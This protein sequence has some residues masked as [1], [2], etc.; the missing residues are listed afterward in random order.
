MWK[1]LHIFKIITGYIL[2]TALLVGTVLAF[3][4]AIPPGPVGVT[5]MKL[6]L[7]KGIRPS[8]QFAI[9]TGL[10]DAIFCMAAIFSTSA[11]VAGLSD[12]SANHPLATM[13]L[14][15]SII[16]GFLVFGVVNLKKKTKAECSSQESENVRQN[17]L[18]IKLKNK[19]PFF[20]GIAIAVANIANPTFLPS[21][22]YLTMQVHQFKFFANSLFN[23]FIF[24]IGFG[25]GNFLW[26]YLLVTVVM[27][28]QS[29]M[30][31]DFIEKIRQFAGITFIG[32]GGFLGWRLL[33]FTKW[34]EIFRLAFAF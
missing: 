27:K 9:G 3:V 15:L 1:K 23:N 21:L 16:F 17:A 34:T 2:P 11:V 24:S 6:G 29:K 32:F 22:A 33:A 4:L 25:I 18:F 26:L 5:A 14:Q 7:T 28:L 20:L 31:P 12:F 10:L 30:P 19:G 13:F 8:V